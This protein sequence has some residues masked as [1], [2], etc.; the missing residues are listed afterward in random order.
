MF[1]QW[2]QWQ[3]MPRMSEVLDGNEQWPEDSAIYPYAEEC[4]S[5]RS[6]DVRE[7][8]FLIGTLDELISGRH[9]TGTANVSR[10]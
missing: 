1:H 6:D 3:F 4:L 9:D 8:L 2:L 5:G 10:H 7:L